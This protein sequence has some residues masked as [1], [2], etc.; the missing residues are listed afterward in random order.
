MKKILN[1]WLC[2]GL[3]LC[4]AACSSN[5][6]TAT[7]PAETTDTPAAAAAATTTPAPI[8]ARADST[9]TLTIP[10]GDSAVT[11]LGELK[12]VNQEM[13]VRV[14]VQGKHRLSATLIAPDS[15]PNIRFA[16]VI[17]PGGEAQGPFGT[18]VSVPTPQDG[19][20][21]LRITHNLRT[22]AGLTREFKMRV[23]LSQ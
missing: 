10:A 12:T 19:T 22:E 11:M 7:T 5:P 9:A 23:V 3:T 6:E 16:Q 14:P 21:T 15:L 18:T 2:L 8:D 20:Y 13:L 1:N 17:R 4:T